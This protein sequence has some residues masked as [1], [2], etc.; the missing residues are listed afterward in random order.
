MKENIENRF[1]VKKTNK[2]YNEVILDVKDLN[3]SFGSK[4]VLK[5][6]NFKLYEGE[7][8][9]I[10]GENG[11]GKTVLIET[12]TGLI[13]KDKGK[14]LLNE[15][16]F[17]IYDSEHK[18][19][20][21]QFQDSS[22]SKSI[23]IS[24]FVKFY[25]SIFPEIINDK[26]IYELMTIFKISDFKKK[27]ISKLSGGQKQRIN[28]MLSIISE[29]KV[30]ILDEFI[31]GLDVSS[32]VDIIRY[33]NDQKERTNSSMIIISHQPEEIKALADRIIVLKDGII[34][35]ETTPQEVELKY[36]SMTDFLVQN[37]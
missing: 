21:V 28:L 8:L 22:I 29:P 33:V 37:I 35:I 15:N 12:I 31:T 36:G 14:I 20:G 2:N 25:K 3:V 27:K 19:F 10:V 24:D 16:K 18:N 4:S 34:K 23:K 9:A 11:A 17:D 13:K 32:V 26:K 30:M 1:E 7:T 5:G 6:V